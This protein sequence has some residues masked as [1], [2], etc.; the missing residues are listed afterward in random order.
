MGVFC[1][2]ALVRLAIQLALSLLLISAGRFVDGGCRY[3][4]TCIIVVIIKG[5][6]FGITQGVL[7]LDLAGAH[8]YANYRQV[9]PVKRGAGFPLLSDRLLPTGIG[10]GT[11]SGT[12]GSLSARVDDKKQ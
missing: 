11:Y 2:G 9:M 3:R 5:A 6:G 12:A 1:V 8:A 7:C 4:K 10:K